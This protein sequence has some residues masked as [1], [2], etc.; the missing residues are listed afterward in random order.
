MAYN[1]SVWI[2]AG[3]GLRHEVYRKSL[4]C[5]GIVFAHWHSPAFKLGLPL[6]AQIYNDGVEIPPELLADL[7]HELDKL[8]QYWQATG[9]GGCEELDRAGKGPNGSMGHIPLPEYLLEK[10]G[11]FRQAICIA[12]TKGGIVGIS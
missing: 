10:A 2:V 3:D 9:T 12:R 7:S 6:V 1:I 5:E 4:G 11:F 8:E